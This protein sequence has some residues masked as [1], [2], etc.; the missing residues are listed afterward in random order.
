V[1]ARRKS[2]GRKKKRRGISTIKQNSRKGFSRWG[3]EEK[4][5][6]DWGVKGGLWRGRKTG[7]WDEQSKIK[8][9]KT[10]TQTITGPRPAK[11]AD[12]IT[13]CRKKNSIP[14]KKVTIKA[15]ER[16]WKMNRKTTALKQTSEEGEEEKKSQQGHPTW[17]DSQVAKNKR[18]VEK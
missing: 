9:R 10:K 4:K 12:K 16:V 18:R 1:P 15:K 17:E 2:G 5:K 8:L 13:D 3:N 14:S 6:K 7:Q 11:K